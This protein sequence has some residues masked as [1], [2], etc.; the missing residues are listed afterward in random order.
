MNRLVRS[1]MKD[2][3]GVALLTVIGV[4][5][6]V[7]ILAIGS[8]ALARQSLHESQRIQ[9]ETRA[10]RAAA[11]G[12]ERALSTFQEDVN[13][14]PMA[15]TTRDGAYSV[16]L[17][18][19]GA[20]RFRLDSA[21]VGD[22][23]LTET[24]SQEFYYINLWRMNFAGAGPQS[25]ISGSSGLHGTSNIIGPFY[26]K[27]N[28]EIRNNMGVFEGPLFVKD[29]NVSVASNA[30]L[31]AETQFI[32]VFCDGDGSPSVP[33]NRDSG[34]GR[35]VFVNSISRSVPDILLPPI[36]QS[37][38]E[39]WSTKAQAES[40]DNVL[41]FHSPESTA[42]PVDNHESTGGADTYKT[43]PPPNTATW[44]R[45]KASATND[46]NANYKFFGAAD[47][48]ISSKG[49]G[50]S[51]LTI[52]PSS[53]GAWGSFSTADGVSLSGPGPA[54][55]GGYD[56]NRHDDFA[57]DAVNSILYI[58]G[59][60]FVDGPL[61]ITRDIL[62]VGNGTIVA[63]GPVNLDGRVRPYSTS[64]SHGH[65]NAQGENNKWALG[66]S[67]PEDINFNGGGDNSYNTMSRPQLRAA[68]PIY[69]GAFYT[70]KIARFNSNNLSVR[71]TVL[72]GK[73]DFQHSNNYLI[74]NPLLP[75][76]LPD[77]LP[78]AAGGILMPGLWTRN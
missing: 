55:V 44:Q 9:D 35:G 4:M 5:S 33:S 16:D 59:T 73:M 65:A 26:M 48:S 27:G 78:G 77:S 21:G 36:T 41:G 61:T 67:T 25:L 56:A 57:Y 1:F 24:V 34:G 19:L 23:G 32:D 66:I 54:G 46:S 62:Y 3:S 31:G 2:E 18:D 63:N 71:G 37:D 76:Y 70:E 20:G 38:L 75:E 12:L 45:S 52:G 13:V 49:S 47:G 30:W 6:V 15:G 51:H 22:D 40:I 68:T 69:A 10:F 60:V 11:S 43:M 39:A 28:F 17:T 53:F 64:S 14:Y 50:V 8:F 7:T 42:T 72:A 29:G 58:A 74:T